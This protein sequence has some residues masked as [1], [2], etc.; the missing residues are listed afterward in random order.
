MA[1][2]FDNIEQDLLGTLRATMQVYQPKLTAMRIAENIPDKF[3]QLGKLGS[4]R[5]FGQS[6][7]VTC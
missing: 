5:K 4:F 1:R 2:I 7:T 6:L 3:G